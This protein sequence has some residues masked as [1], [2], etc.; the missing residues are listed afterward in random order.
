MITE[1]QFDGL[2]LKLKAEGRLSTVVKDQ[3]VVA[4][5]KNSIDGKFNSLGQVLG[6]NNCSD[7]LRLSIGV[8]QQTSE[9][10]ITLTVWI[11]TRRSRNKCNTKGR[12]MFLVV[13]T[14]SLALEAS[15][16]DYDVLAKHISGIISERPSD[17]K[18]GKFKL[19]KLQFDLGSTS[20][21]VIMPQYKR[22]ANVTEQQMALLRKLR[23]LS[24][25]TKFQLV[26]NYDERIFAEIQDVCK[27]Q[28]YKAVAPSVILEKLYSSKQSDCI[29]EWMRQGWC[30][31]DSTDQNVSIADKDVET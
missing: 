26:A 15:C 2:A 22:Q 28:S 24:E 1:V 3:P 7:I 29:D 8:N 30:A 10:F 6:R 13:P 16:D 21:Y 4:V 18:S 20:S 27:I 12:L 31:E 14:E 9:L 17:D 11:R 23:S 19:L 5:Y 25:S